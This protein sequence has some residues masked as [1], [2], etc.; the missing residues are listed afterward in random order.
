MDACPLTRAAREKSPLLA[1]ALQDSSPAFKTYSAHLG[2]RRER[3]DIPLAI[4][5]LFGYLEKNIPFSPTAL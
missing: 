1:F 3:G 5:P 2:N 4:F